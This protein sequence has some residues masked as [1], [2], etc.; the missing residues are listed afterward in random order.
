MKNIKFILI[1]VLLLNVSIAFAECDMFAGIAKDGFYISELNSEPGN[2]DDPNDF[3]EWIKLRSRNSAPKPNNDG[4]GVLYYKDYGYFYLDPANLGHSEE[5][6]GNPNNQAW[7]QIDYNTFY[8]DG[9]ENMQWELNTAS[10]VIMNYNTEASIVLAH[11]R[12]GSGGHGNHP[13]RFNI[14]GDYKT[15]T[16]MHNGWLTSDLETPIYNYLLDLGWFNTYSS[17]WEDND[18]IDSEILFHYIMKFVIDNNGDIVAGVH[19]ALTQTNIDGANIREELE[20]PVAYH[21]TSLGGWTY[22]KVANFIMS[23]GENLYIFRNS[24]S[25]DN[26]PA[27]NDSLH[28]LSYTVHD[29]FTAVKTYHELDTRVDQFDFVSIPR[30]GQSIEI[31]DFLDYTPASPNAATLIFPDHG[32]TGMPRQVTVDWEYNKISLEVPTGF[33]VYKGAAEVADIAYTSDIIYTHVFSDLIWNETVSWKVVPYNNNGDFVS[34]EVWEFTVMSEPDNPDEVPSEIV[35]TEEVYSGSDPAIISLP[36]INLG[37]GNVNPTIDFSYSSSET[38]FN[39]TILVQDQPNNPLPY[40]ENC[41]ASFTP[42]LPNNNETTLTF[43]F[44]GTLTPNVLLHWNESGW[45]DV[46]TLANATFGVGFVTFAWTSTGRGNE[47]FVVNNGGESP[48]P[49]SLSSFTTTYGNGSPII[50]WVTQSESDNIGWNVYRSYSSNF[51]QAQI[52]NLY[53][54]PGNGTTSQPS[55]YSFTDEYEVHENFTYWYWLE[56][57]SG[58][59]ITESYGPVSLT[60]PLEGNDIPE[61]PMVTELHQN[62]PNPFNPS[63]LISFNIK[64]NETGVLSIYNI[65]GQLIVK[66]EFEAGRHYYAWDARDHSS[67]IYLYKLQTKRYSKIMKMLLVK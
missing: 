62:F 11:A 52:L 19:E 34:P 8:T 3:F 16:F 1:A 20:N 24:P 45:E 28:A 59:G 12:Q 46:T 31:P 58:S 26:A 39:I 2:F 48:L 9:T 13:F 6:Q 42:N 63:T 15:Y 33:K 29:Y 50:N 66:S 10:D 65:K 21:S 40:P 49:V 47:I 61:I 51:G 25:V 36:A 57:I 7:Y 41:A 5:D 38:N 56:S 18:M 17:N 67:G 27:F 23:D 43:N 35:Y 14:I 4:Y 30:H 32:I 53:T 22:N 64:E 55:F 37:E 54:I 44:S 60:I